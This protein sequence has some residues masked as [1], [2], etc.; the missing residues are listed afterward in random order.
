MK[1][2]DI[3]NKTA[4]TPAPAG[5][6]QARA[7]VAQE[8]TVATPAAPSTNVQLSPLSTQ[9]Q[10]LQSTQASSSVFATKKSKKLNWPFQRAASKSTQKKLPTVFWSQ[11]KI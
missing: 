6:Q 7:D 4:T 10:A 11:L 9:L 8:S 1:I 5:P 3:L 2:D